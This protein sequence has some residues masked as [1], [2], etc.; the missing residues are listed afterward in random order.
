MWA[1]IGIFKPAEPSSPL[2]SCW[3]SYIQNSV[4]C[5]VH[6]E[7]RVNNQGHKVYLLLLPVCVWHTTHTICDSPCNFKT[8]FIRCIMYSLDSDTWSLTSTAYR[9]CTRLT[10]LPSLKFVCMPANRYFS[11]ICRV[12]SCSTRDLDLLSFNCA[13][14]QYPMWYFVDKTSPC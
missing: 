3:Y 5:R 2:S 14:F 13:S 7:A 12:T 6:S 11:A 9:C 8:V 4:V 10:Y 1:W